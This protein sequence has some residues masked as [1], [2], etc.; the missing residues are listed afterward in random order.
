[1]AGARKIPPLS[2][3][4][5]YGPM[6]LFPLLALVAWLAPPFTALLATQA[7]QAWGGVLLVFLAGVRRGLS[8]F[9]DGGPRPIQIVTMFWLFLLGLAA[10][11]APAFVAFPLLLIGFGSI[12]LLDPRAAQ[13]GEAP[14]FFAKL[15]P[16]QMLVTLIGL[17]AIEVRLFA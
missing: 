17:A 3:L 5:G 15:R 4:L 1:M 14:E 2:L 7:A 10:L 11:V 9:T 13:R 8:F 12:A 6:A 16:P